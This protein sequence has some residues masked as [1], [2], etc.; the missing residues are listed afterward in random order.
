MEA[1][2]DRTA[3]KFHP[4]FVSDEYVLLEDGVPD[5]SS[6]CDN[7]TDTLIASSHYHCHQLAQQQGPRRANAFTFSEQRCT[8]YACR[9]IDTP[10]A[11]THTRHDVYRIRE[12]GGC[13][14]SSYLPL[15]I[16]SMYF[17]VLPPYCLRDMLFAMAIIKL[18]PVY[19]F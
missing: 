6:E 16:S 18:S 3:I 17:L 14:C 9:F 11:T 15:R 10:L 7:L 12:K 8:I 5:V 13:F 1:S 2:G 4:C 19:Y